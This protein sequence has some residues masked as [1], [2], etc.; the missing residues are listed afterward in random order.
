MK[1]KITKE[2][3]ITYIKN[4]E[5]WVDGDKLYKIEWEKNNYPNFIFNNPNLFTEQLSDNY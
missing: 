2:K 1:Q 3:L 5:T 4:K